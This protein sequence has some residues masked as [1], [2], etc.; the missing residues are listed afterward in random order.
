M[1][2]DSIEK[3]RE[4]GEPRHLFEFKVGDNLNAFRYTDHDRPVEIAASDGEIDRYLPLPIEYSKIE[5]DGTLGDKTVNITLPIA[6]EIGARMTAR[7]LAMTT[8]VNISQ[9]HIIGNNRIDDAL[10]IFSGIVVGIEAGSRSSPEI[11]ITCNPGFLEMDKLAGSHNYSISCPYQL[12]SNLCGA[13]RA[14]QNIRVVGFLSDGYGILVENTSNLYI[15]DGAGSFE[16]GTTIAGGTIE[17]ATADGTEI[18]TIIS[19]RLHSIDADGGAIVLLNLSDRVTRMERQIVQ[20]DRGCQRNMRDC[21][22]IHNNLRNF[23]GQPWIPL[24][25]PVNESFN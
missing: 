19:S 9:Y 14:T 20:F 23:G 22:D 5:N 6:S 16:K 10:T 11:K 1:S 15:P 8:K 21:K 7:T 13:R 3:S 24:K 12:Y 25:N 4:D 17:W 18:R 2:F